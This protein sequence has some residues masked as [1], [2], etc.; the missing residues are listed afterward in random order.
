MQ[1]TLDGA[2]IY[3]LNNGNM[4]SPITSKEVFTYQLD[5]KNGHTD[6]T[7]LTIDMVP[8]IVSTNPNDVL[9]GSA[10][11]YTLI[12]H[13]LNSTDAT[14]GNSA[15]RWQNFSTA[16]LTAEVS[17][18]SLALP[19]ELNDWLDLVATETR[20]YK[21]RRAQLADPEVEP[22]AALAS[23]NKDLAITQRLEKAV[24]PAT[25]KYCD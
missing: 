21:S 9:I 8:Q 15:D 10:Y 1:I 14:G 20:L 12:Y 7:T 16:R 6:S 17:D 11:S 22:R 5:D 19:D 23:V 3:T 4:M 2:Y 18:F 25:L 24:R 13:L